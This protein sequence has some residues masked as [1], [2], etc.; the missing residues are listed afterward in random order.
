MRNSAYFNGKSVHKA[1]VHFS[2]A[3]RGK[4]RVSGDLGF[5]PE[6]FDWITSNK[7][8]LKKKHRMFFAFLNVINFV[9]IHLW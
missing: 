2:L 6:M 1:N 5:S 7:L 4:C 8:N 3:S 9:N